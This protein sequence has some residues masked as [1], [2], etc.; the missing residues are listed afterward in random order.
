LIDIPDNEVLVKQIIEASR[1]HFAKQFVAKAST[2]KP[3]AIANKRNFKTK[4]NKKSEV[5]PD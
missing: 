2:F 5:F 4:T 3:K 1:E